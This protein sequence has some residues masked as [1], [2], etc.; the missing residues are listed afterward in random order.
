MST[1]L[2]YRDTDSYPRQLARNHSL[3]AAHAG[4]SLRTHFR[5][6]MTIVEVRGALDAHNAERLS[7]HI[8]DLAT[9]DRPLI[10]DLYSVDFFGSDGFR[11]LVK[12]AETCQREGLRWALV[13]SRAVDRLLD[14]DNGNHAFPAAASLDEAMRQLTPPGH[15]WS[16][17]QRI[18]PTGSRGASRVSHRG[19]GVP[20]MG[21]FTEKL[22]SVLMHHELSDIPAKQ[23]HRWEDEGGFIPPERKPRRAFTR[24]SRTCGHS[25]GGG[26]AG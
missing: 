18:A 22:K 10:I 20:G 24:R 6:E 9:S 7:D 23:I 5:P 15:A 4:M 3:A 8:D 19:R 14:T 26:K 17:P 25:F 13:T 2:E 1:I 16:P 12:V 11:A 21:K